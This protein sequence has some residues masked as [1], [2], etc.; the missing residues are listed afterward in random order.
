MAMN[1]SV[2]KSEESTQKEQ[3]SSEDRSEEVSEVTSAPV[4]EVPTEATAEPNVIEG[5]SSEAPAEIPTAEP[6]VIEGTSSEAPTEGTID[7]QPKSLQQSFTK[8]IIKTV[9]PI[10]RVDPV[11]QDIQYF[12]I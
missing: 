7:S 2:V 8:N 11:K 4:S 1:D 5:T 12:C 3:P 6:N 10:H 9:I